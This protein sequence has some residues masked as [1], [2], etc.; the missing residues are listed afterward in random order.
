MDLGP[1]HG[2]EGRGGVRGIKRGKDR[3]HPQFLATVTLTRLLNPPVILPW[4]FF[5]DL[6]A[7]FA[8][9]FVTRLRHRCRIFNVFDIA[10]RRY[11]DSVP[12]VNDVLE[13]GRN[14]AN[15]FV[16]G[17]TAKLISTHRAHGVDARSPRDGNYSWPL[18]TSV[19]DG[20]SSPSVASTRSGTT[21]W[22]GRYAHEADF[23]QS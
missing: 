11:R 18:S 14:C 1:L 3:L 23:H 5:P 9:I 15:G 8:P 17:G 6:L 21:D 16:Y 2:E 22:E 4:E 19:S 20:R 10:R 13:E 7:I 12:I